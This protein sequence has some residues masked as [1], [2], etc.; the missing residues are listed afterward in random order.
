MERSSCAPTWAFGY[1]R[2]TIIFH[3]YPE[4][5]IHSEGQTGVLL[6]HSCSPVC[7]KCFLQY[8]SLHSILG[9][10]YLRLRNRTWSY[11][12][13]LSPSPVAPFVSHTQYLVLTTH[14]GEKCRKP[15]P[16]LVLH[17]FSLLL[18]VAGVLCK[19]KKPSNWTNSFLSLPS[20][21]L[22]QT[23]SP[24]NATVFLACL[25]CC[26]CAANSLTHL[27]PSGARGCLSLGTCQAIT[28]NE[29][30]LLT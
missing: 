18:P 6:C 2:H 3:P 13:L 5:S 16:T 23:F 10:I 21:L 22:S 28:V 19:K 24:T 17:H 25:C 14:P 20:V 15:P 7:H 12:A 30:P 26:C 9:P 27:L 11:A 8:T 1:G 4:P 29:N